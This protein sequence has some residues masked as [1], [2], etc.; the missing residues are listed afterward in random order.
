MSIQF[1]ENFMRITLWK[2]AIFLHLREGAKNAV[3]GD[4]KTVGV[5]ALNFQVP[6]VEV[7]ISLLKKSSVPYDN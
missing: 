6:T 7:D 5:G 2:I 4:T 1:D 3:R